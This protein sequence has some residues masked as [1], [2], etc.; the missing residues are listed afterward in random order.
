MGW[1]QRMEYWGV[2]IGLGIGRLLPRGM[3]YPLASRIVKGSFGPGSRRHGRILEHLAIAFPE[4]S[5]EER[6]AI[7]TEYRWHKA[8]FFV[9]TL[10]ML[11]GRFDYEGSVVNLDE[12]RERIAALKG[13]SGKGIL[14]LVSHYGNWE[15][16]AQFFALNGF[17]GT[18]V[19]KEHRRN[20][21]IDERIIGPYRRGFGHRVIERKGAL[22]AI[23]RILKS[24]EG[25]GMHIDQMIPPPN[26]VLVD[27]FGRPAY[28]S[29]SMAQLKLRFDPLMVPIFAVR[30]GRERFRILIGEPEEYRAEELEDRDEKIRC[31]TQS[32]TELLE[33]R[34]RREPAQWEWS[35]RRWR[36]PKE[37]VG[38]EAQSAGR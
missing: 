2:R 33:E 20:P 34:I 38:R 15:F 25:V 28:A 13:R 4:A 21:L 6:E 5:P 16:L 29:K 14:F 7:A 1:K 22:R 12:A 30:E 9:E 23:A 19:A 32:Y 26:G 8:H 11:T 27:F 36:M 17:P 37:A 10:L 18:L 35:Y 24:R 31:I 3:L